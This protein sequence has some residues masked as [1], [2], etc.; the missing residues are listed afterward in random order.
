MSLA[1]HIRRLWA[2]REHCIAPKLP[3]DLPVFA[4]KLVASA[5][6]QEKRM[7]RAGEIDAEI[8]EAIKVMRE[9]GIV[10]LIIR[11]RPDAASGVVCLDEDGRAPWEQG[12]REA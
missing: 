1:E 6:W 4:K 2:E 5:A 9:L 3:G 11:H 10:E 7:E 12:Y 8:D